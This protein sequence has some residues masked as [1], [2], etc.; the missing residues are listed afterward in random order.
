[1]TIRVATSV[2][3]TAEDFYQQQ[4]SQSQIPILSESLTSFQIKIT[5]VVVMIAVD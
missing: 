4:I 3:L 5:L 1:L 2:T